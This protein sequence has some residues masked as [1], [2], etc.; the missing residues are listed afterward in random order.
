MNTSLSTLLE[1]SM[2]MYR[3]IK[4]HATQELLSSSHIFSKLIV[5]FGQAFIHF[6]ELHTSVDL[7]CA[8]WLCRHFVQLFQLSSQFYIFCCWSLLGVHKFLNELI[9][10]PQLSQRLSDL[11]Y[12][13]SKQLFILLTL[14]FIVI[15]IMY[16]ATWWHKRGIEVAL[17]TRHVLVTIILR[18]VSGRLVITCIEILVE[19]THCWAARM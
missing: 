1:I 13:F 7:V 19:G 2:I 14:S 17:M 10:L 18:V 15:V 4:S 9:L 12:V 11:I 16:T 5:F 6:L 3:W 8:H